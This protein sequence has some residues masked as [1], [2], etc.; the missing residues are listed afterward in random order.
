MGG[1]E[2]V[3]AALPAAASVKAVLPQHLQRPHTCWRDLWSPPCTKAL[4]DVEELWHLTRDHAHSMIPVWWSALQALVNEEKHYAATI[5]TTGSLW[6]TGSPVTNPSFLDF[7]GRRNWFLFLN[8]QF[9]PLNSLPA[10][11][12]ERH[13]LW[14]SACAAGG[15]SARKNYSSSSHYLETNGRRSQTKPSSIIF[16]WCY[17]RHAAPTGLGTAFYCLWFFPF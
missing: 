16:I 8:V 2:S 11:G 15:L 9:S 14:L 10:E 12:R 6:P 7:T 3:S 17:N 1:D 5:G 4:G 13:E